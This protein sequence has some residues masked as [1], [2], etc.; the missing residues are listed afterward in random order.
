M[1][2]K[3]KKE[4]KKGSWYN[5]DPVLFTSF[6]HFERQLLVFLQFFNLLLVDVRL[7]WTRH[8]DYVDHLL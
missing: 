7:I 6:A 2:Q 4:K 5:H 1:N 3:K 8:I